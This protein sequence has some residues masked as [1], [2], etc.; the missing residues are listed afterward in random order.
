MRNTVGVTS[1]SMSNERSCGVYTTRMSAAMALY[2][3]VRG[4]ICHR[5]AAAK[6]KVGYG[7]WGPSTYPHPKPD[8]RKYSSIG[9]VDRLVRA[10]EMARIAAI[11][12]DPPGI[13]RFT[14]RELN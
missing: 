3:I 11:M 12:R 1:V 13:M 14:T 6:S 4:T 2:L 9:S 7:V 8:L 5:R 10:S